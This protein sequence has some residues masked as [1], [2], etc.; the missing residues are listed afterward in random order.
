MKKAAIA[1]GLFALVTVVVLAQSSNDLFQQALVKERTEGKFNEAIK[2][3]QTIIQKYSSDRKVVAKALFQMGQAYEKLGSA[4]AKKA[5]ERIA[6]EFADQ[7]EIAAD[8]G[9]R[10]SVLSFPPTPNQFAPRLL[11]TGDDVDMDASFSPD[12]N[13]MAMVDWSTNDGHL[14]IRDMSTGQLK[15]LQTGTCRKGAKNCAFAE[16]PVFS[17]DMRQVAYIWYDDSEIDGQSQLRVIA[18]EVGA[19]PKVL[20]RN[21]EINV[22]A[23]GWSPDGKSILVVTKRPDRTWQLGWV[24]ATDGSIKVI[25]SLDWRFPRDVHLSPDGRYVAY[26]ALAN[27]P[28]KAPPAVPESDERHIYSLAADGSVETELAKTASINDHPIW[29]A[30]G[31]HV[32]FTSNQSGTTDLWA[33]AVNNGRTQGSPSLIRREVGEILP[34]AFVRSGAFYYSQRRQ[35]GIDQVSIVD[36]TRGDQT[37]YVDAFAG[38]N[39]AWSPDGKSIAFVRNSSAGGQNYDLV[40]RSIDTR[41]EKVYR[42]KFPQSDNHMVAKPLWLPDGKSLLKLVY[43]GDAIQDGAWHSVDLKT[44]DFKEAIKRTVDQTAIAALARDGRLLYLFSRDPAI[45]ATTGRWD[46]VVALGVGTGQEKHVLTLPGAPDTLPRPGEIAIAVSPEGRSL[47]IATYNPKTSTAHLAVAG[48][49]GSAYRDIYTFQS[50]RTMDKL[51]WSADGRSI[52][53]ASNPDGA[54]WKLMRIGVEGGTA[55]F[56]GLAINGLG[57]FDLSPDGTRIA[58]DS[59]AAATSGKELLVIDNLSALLK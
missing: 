36:F 22:R 27:N 56:T 33:V 32:V 24:S 48:V 39:P 55:E 37:R 30:D 42:K 35:S 53:F 44:G 16:A 21:P 9:R 8:A 7:K 34:L 13:W 11:L 49:D 15:R 3:Y 23:S 46:R 10:L 19:K 18:N 6:R 41:D 12:G 52:L 40:V 51:A 14:A 26:S 38:L 2:I 31:A 4:E 50:V 58:F 28:A 20:V 59:R 25:K 54:N 45:K 57:S 43:W 17:P 1:I 5:Y 29:T 47:A